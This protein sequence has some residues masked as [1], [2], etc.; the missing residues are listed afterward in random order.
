MDQSDRDIAIRALV[1]PFRRWDLFL[2]CAI[3]PYTLLVAYFALFGYLNSNEAAQSGSL[4]TAFTFC[5]IL[6]FFILPTLYASYL[7]NWRRAMIFEGTSLES[8]PFLRVDRLTIQTYAYAAGGRD[9]VQNHLRQSAHSLRTAIIV[10]IASMA[11]SF[12]FSIDEVRAV[13]PYVDTAVLLILIYSAFIYFGSGRAWQAASASALDIPETR[14]VAPIPASRLRLIFGPIA[15]LTFAILMACWW[16]VGTVRFSVSTLENDLAG[17]V[18]LAAIFITNAWS[19]AAQSLIYRRSM[20]L[21]QSSVHALP[22]M[23]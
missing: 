22:N 10:V 21:P 18:W 11:A 6:S 5:F 3:L 9:E 20:S 4:T 13:L 12:V 17:A 2:R 19:S 15:V 14:K 8:S 7:A 16:I 1:S 23:A